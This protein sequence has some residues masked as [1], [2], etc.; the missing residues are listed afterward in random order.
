MK[1]KLGGK[2]V[3][4]SKTIHK[5]LNPVWDE[6]VSLLVES[7]KEPLYV[8]VKGRLLL[9]LLLLLLGWDCVEVVKKLSKT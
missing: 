2:E 9:L 4:R 7:L 8:K 1:F 6:R 3:F 5:N